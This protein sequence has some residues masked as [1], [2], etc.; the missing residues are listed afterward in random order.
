MIIPF[1]RM[2]VD[3]SCLGNHELDGGID[4]AHKL[5]KQTNCPWILTNLLVKDRAMRPILDLMPY[6]IIEHQGFKIGVLGFAE[7]GWLELLVL[8]IDTKN[9]LYVD[10]NESLQKYSKLLR[11]EHG[12][13][14][15]VA[16]N[17]MRIP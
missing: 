4:L 7:E 15:I 9:L 2:N 3:V 17:H 1:N 12:C 16:L 14:I 8:E 5:I 13:E 10:Y 11:E 6:H